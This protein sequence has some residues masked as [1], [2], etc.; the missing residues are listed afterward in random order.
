MAQI[1]IIDDDPQF[2]KTLYAILAKAG[3][4]VLEAGNGNEGLQIL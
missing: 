1:L 4:D 2:R 3:Y